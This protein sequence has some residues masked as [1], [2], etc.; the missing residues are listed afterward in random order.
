MS[1]E[2]INPPELGPVE[3]RLKLSGDEATV[4]FVSAHAD[5]R[6]AI[7]AA[8][9]RLRESMAQAGISLGETSVSAESFREQ[10]GQDS[11]HRGSR[12]G[13]GA[14]RDEAEPAWSR[15]AI[16]SGVRRGLVDLFA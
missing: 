5:V 1:L 9:S 3:V 13:Y 7:E 6:N 12:S 16:S 15:T 4:Q 11:E 8:V 2:R 14:E 10:A